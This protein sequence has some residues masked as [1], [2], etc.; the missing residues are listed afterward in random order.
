MSDQLSTRPEKL[1]QRKRSVR[2]TPCS[3]WTRARRGL[4]LAQ[5]AFAVGIAYA[6]ISL[7]WGFGGT[8]L[9]DTV[10][11]AL[12]KLSHTQSALLLFIVWV[13]V[14]LKMIASFLPLLVVQAGD[15]RPTAKTWW[16]HS[17][18]LLGWTEAGILTLYGLVLTAVELLAESGAI[19][20]PPHAD[21]LALAWHAYLWDPW[22]LLWGLLVAGVMAR[23]YVRQ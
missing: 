3:G 10:S 16:G 19:A 17:L 18:R 23:T 15:P 9:V 4:R 20:V 14:V 12:P 11:S 13:A 21:R 8:W 1:Q 6:A 7:Y 5:V 2:W 22:F